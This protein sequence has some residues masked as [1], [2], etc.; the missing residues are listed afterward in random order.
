VKD[1][2]SFDFSGSKTNIVMM[3]VFSSTIFARN[4]HLSDSKCHITSSGCRGWAT[5]WKCYPLSFSD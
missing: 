5:S 2:L 1:Q 4:F 3:M